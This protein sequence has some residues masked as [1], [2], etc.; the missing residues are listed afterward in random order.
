ML[1][2]V[3]ATALE[4]V[5]RADD[6]AVHVAVRILLGVPNTGLCREVDDP[7]EARLGKEPIHPGAVREIELGEAEALLRQE[8]IEPRLLELR[9]VVR[10]QV[11]EPDDLIAAVEQTMRSEAADEAGGAGDEYAHGTGMV[12]AEG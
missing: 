6:V 10:I 1:H 11:V 9:V 12:R 8:A 3:V 4:H 7:I 2:A 5:Q